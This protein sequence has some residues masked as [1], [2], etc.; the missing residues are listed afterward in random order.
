MITCFTTF[1]GE[2]GS[3]AWSES[4]VEGVVYAR[5]SHMRKVKEHREIVGT[6]IYYQSM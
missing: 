1:A 3:R 4:A 6:D 5:Q 2:F